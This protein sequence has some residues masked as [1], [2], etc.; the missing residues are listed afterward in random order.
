MPP[1][2]PV[3]SV[4]PQ[5]D[6]PLRIS[7]VTNASENQYEPRLTYVVTNISGKPIS[8]YA[9]RHI[10]AFGG[11]SDSGVTIHQSVSPDQVLFP[12]QTEEGSMESTQYSAAVQSVNIIVDFVQFTDGSQWGPD[13][14]KS[15][16]RLAGQTAG[17]QT[18][19]SRLLKIENKNGTAAVIHAIA[20]D[21]LDNEVPAGH[22]AEWEE[23]FR[24]GISFE[25]GLLRRANERG[26]V[27]EVKKELREPYGATERRTR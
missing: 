13:K 19:V 8:A 18:E 20:S 11:A 5:P 10:V 16:E 3:L 26:G 27:N 21:A 9:I 6:A 24:D 7:S 15:A 17:A 25:R 2:S 1:Q 4:Q 22:T 12:T 14:F 23:G